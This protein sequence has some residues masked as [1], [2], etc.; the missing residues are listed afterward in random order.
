MGLAAGQIALD[1]DLDALEL[2]SSLKPICRVYQNAV[3][4]IPN[5][6]N[7]IITFTAEDIDTHGFHSTSVNTG[8]ITP[9]VAG[10]Y[11]FTGTLFIAGATDYSN[12]AVWVRKN[13]ATALQPAARIGNMA[14][15]QAMSLITSAMVDMNGTTDYVELVALQVNT[16][17]A[18]RNTENTLGAGRVCVLESEYLRGPA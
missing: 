17:V 8:R 3:Q 10:I 16:A 2:A 1:T 11:R 18:S 12:I 4:S 5:N 13:G 14:S 7:T 6:A 15:S 9:T